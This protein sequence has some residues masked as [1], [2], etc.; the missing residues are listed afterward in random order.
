M[1]EPERTVR[2]PLTIRAGA[3]PFEVTVMS[4]GMLV[5]LVGLLDPH[6]RSPAISAA[7]GTGTV[8]WYVSLTLWCGMV[9]GAV[10]P[11]AIAAARRGWSTLVHPRGQERLEIRLRIEQ[12]G[13]IG[14]SGTAA[15]YAPAAMASSGAT[16]STA[17]IWIGLFA[18]AALW[19]A[20]EIYVDL[21][22]LHRAWRD[23]HPAFPIPLG[24]PRGS[25]R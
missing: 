8:Y 13:M 22:A 19:R 12:A 21:R 6:A 20:G 18:A 23:P 4:G 1:T 7:F 9:L 24:D 5:G 14:F 25:A 10:A 2:P 17:G 15:A 3:R 11:Q 16:G